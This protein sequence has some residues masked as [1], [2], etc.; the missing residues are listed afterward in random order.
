MKNMWNN[1]KKICLQLIHIG[2]IVPW[3]AQELARNIYAKSFC[4]FLGMPKKNLGSSG[5]GLRAESSNLRGFKNRL[6]LSHK[7]ELYHP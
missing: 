2:H 6:N 3:F 7:H 1:P 5:R 4:N